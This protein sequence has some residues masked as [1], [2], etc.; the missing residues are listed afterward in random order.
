MTYGWPGLNYF[1]RSEDSNYSESC[2]TL[3]LCHPGLDQGSFGGVFSIKRY[4][5]RIARW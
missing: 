3:A 4:R 5:V 1:M 2:H